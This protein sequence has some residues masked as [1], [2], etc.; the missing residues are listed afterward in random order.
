MFARHDRRLAGELPAEMPGDE[1]R[2]GVVGA[3]R[4]DRDDDRDRLAA[5]ELRLLAGRRGGDHR[6]H[7]KGNPER[8][9]KAAPA[10]ASLSPKGRESG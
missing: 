3:A 2:I 10:R 4:P 6:Q 7:R 8:D 1:A 5:V 9:C